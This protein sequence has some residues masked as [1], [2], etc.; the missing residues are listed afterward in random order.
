MLKF[1]AQTT[2]I[3]TIIN[4][5]EKALNGNVYTLQGTLVKKSTEGVNPLYGLE[6]GIYVVNGKKMVVE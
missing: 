6:K 3:N 4:M 1:D 5:A 2:G